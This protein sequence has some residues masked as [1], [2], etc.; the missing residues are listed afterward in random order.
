MQYVARSRVASFVVS[1]DFFGCWF[2]H[3]SVLCALQDDTVS[4]FSRRQSASPILPA[5][6]THRRHRI[7]RIR[8][9]CPSFEHQGTFDPL[10]PG[11]QPLRVRTSETP[12]SASQRACSRLW[13]RALVKRAKNPI[14]EM[15]RFSHKADGTDPRRILRARMDFRAGSERLPQRRDMPCGPVRS[16]L[17]SAKVPHGSPA[18]VVVIQLLA[19]TEA[20][21][22]SLR[23]V[24]GEI[25]IR[26][27]TLMWIAHL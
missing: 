8:N 18:G 2:G 1:D 13:T 7:G 14:R 25:L 4:S 17:A 19:V 24:C 20:R 22:S 5:M 21:Q 26:R 27:V 16:R 11:D 23:Q 3:M 12:V 9:A 10:D 6:P 15:S